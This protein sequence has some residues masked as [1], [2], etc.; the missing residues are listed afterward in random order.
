M[1][2]LLTSHRTIINKESFSEFISK[3]IFTFIPEVWMFLHRPDFSVSLCAPICTRTLPWHFKHQL[4]PWGGLLSPAGQMPTP[5]QVQWRNS[6][7]GG[8]ASWAPV[9]PIRAEHGDTSQFQIARKLVLSQ[10]VKDY[11]SLGD[12]RNGIV[13]EILASLCHCAFDEK[14][15]ASY[16]LAIPRTH[17]SWEGAWKFALFQNAKHVFLRQTWTHA[18]KFP[19]ISKQYQSTISGPNLRVACKVT[20]EDRRRARPDLSS[21]GTL[22][23]ACSLSW[24]DS[25]PDQSI[26]CE[27]QRAGDD[28]TQCGKGRWVLTKLLGGSENNSHCQ[29]SCKRRSGGERNQKSGTEMMKQ[30]TGLKMYGD[31]KEW[32]RGAGVGRSF[33]E[34]GPWSFN[35]S[36]GTGESSQTEVCLE[37]E[38]DPPLLT[39]QEGSGH[40]VGSQRNGHMQIASS[41]LV[42]Y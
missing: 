8:L 3:N 41:F 31:N 42:K 24:A 32:V 39:P 25:D 12:Q 11:A 37:K 34:S 6:L 15:E 9:V 40:Q 4:C 38:G 35:I 16:W 22:S 20:W 30:Y 29:E 14:A 19:S 7:L 28:C 36:H 1:G 5:A 13:L 23:T 27:L 33:V 17:K 10:N 26:P 18:L 21:P 2:L